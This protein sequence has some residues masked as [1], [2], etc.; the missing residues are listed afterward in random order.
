M[1]KKTAFTEFYKTLVEKSGE[2]THTSKWDRCVEHVG[3]QGGANAYAVCTAALGEAAF[4]SMEAG[5]P[6]FLKEVDI[7][8]GKLGISGA[9]PVPSSLLA[10]QDLEG[11]TRKS[12]FS[13][14]ATKCWVVRCNGADSRFYDKKE[15]M[16]CLETVRAS[17]T[18]AVL[19]E[20][21]VMS[22]TEKG[23][24]ETTG[25]QLDRAVDAAK[26]AD[27]PKETETLVDRI[28][29]IQIRRQK[30]TTIAR[31][32]EETTGKTFKQVWKGIK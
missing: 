9:G 25:K 23:A 2:S 6:N 3:Q 28:K 24:I 7:F 12:T 30:A 10:G 32:R 21:T 15:A 11:S 22:E 13:K 17:G 31:E 8:L 1:A 27:T 18:Y 5:D 14:A 19:V 26:K 16:E 4:K 29:N 20:E